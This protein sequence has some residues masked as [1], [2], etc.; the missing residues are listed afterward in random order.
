MQEKQKD[1]FCVHWT[2][3]QIM[4]GHMLIWGLF[5][6]NLKPDLK[7]LSNICELQ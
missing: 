2:P 3:I 7:R 4:I 5:F 6:L 1:G